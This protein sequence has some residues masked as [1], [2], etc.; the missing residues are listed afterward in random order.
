[1]IPDT[2]DMLC[3]SLAFLFL[4]PLSIANADA[5]DSEET[6]ADEVLVL[7]EDVGRWLATNAL[8]DEN[9]VAWPDDVLNSEAVSYD[10]AS[11]VAGKVIF[12]V[13]LYRATENPEYLELALGGA[14]YLLATLQ[15]PTAFNGN[16][17]KAS[18]YTG[19]SGIGV[20]LTHVH[21]QTDGAK[22]AQG[23]E[24]IVA[25]LDEW[26]VVTEEG[27]RWSDEFNDLLYGDTGTAL[28]LSWYA[29]QSGDE[30]AGV[31]AHAGAR[32]MLAEADESSQG[33]SW[34]F[35]RSK[36]FNL[37]NFSHGT[38]GV[39]YMLASVGAATEDQ[40]LLR[41]AQAGFHYLK[42]IAEI[43][44]GQLHIPYGWGSDN[45]DGLYEFGWAHG[46]AGTASLFVRLQQT[47]ID[48]ESAAEYER[49]ARHTL[50]RINLPGMPAAPFA[51]PST[52]LDQRFGRAGVLSSFSDWSP[53]NPEI[54][55]LR[56]EIW[57]HIAEAAVRENDAAHW[58]VDAPDFMG[59]GRAAYTGVLHGAAGI[60]LAMLRMHARMSGR[61][62]Y[63]DLPDHPVK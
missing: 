46:L 37:P 38:A 8:V 33:M 50:Q 4:L 30:R 13:A 58:E 60:G 6:L 31:M 63:V 24:K 22:Y 59:G 36:P 39:A 3:R 14:D 44:D 48:V 25:L 28:F 52:P 11:G 27:I 16:P 1:M 9:S 53:D 34:Y 55:A 47:G 45:W 43:K 19:V 32:F 18:L 26:S 62:A 15:D 57:A 29:G 42:S 49:L 61:Q 7:A 56:D 20:A 51:E 12:F 21:Q 5:I 40:T 54:A 2:K 10:L 41:G 17:R 23:L 35:R